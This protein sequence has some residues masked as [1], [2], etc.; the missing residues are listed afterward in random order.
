MLPSARAVHAP[1]W[2]V[3]TTLDEAWREARRTEL[4]EDVFRQELGAEWISGAGQFFDLRGIPLEDGPARARGRP[5]LDCGTGSGLRMRSL[6][7]RPGRRV[8]PRAG[9][10]LVGRVEALEP[11]PRLLSFERRRAR[12]DRMLDQVC[13]DHPAVRADASSPISTSP[14]RSGPTSVV[15]ARPSP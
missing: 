14:M 5:E 15:G 13:G 7:L 12:E 2:E 3:D 9:V 10:L 1:V 8:G 4:G 6:R 11:G